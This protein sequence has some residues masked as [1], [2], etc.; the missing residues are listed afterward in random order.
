MT[1]RVGEHHAGGVA[2][3]AGEATKFESLLA[4]Q[5]VAATPPKEW[6]VVTIDLW[7]LTGR[8]MTIGSMSLSTIG[9]AALFDRILLGRTEADVAAKKDSIE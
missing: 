7:K 6:T 8:E 4:T 1:L 5:Q 2:L 3:H 9:G